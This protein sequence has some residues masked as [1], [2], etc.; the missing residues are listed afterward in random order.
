LAGKLFEKSV[1]KKNELSLKPTDRLRL[2]EELKP[3]E[4]YFFLLE[5]LWR[6]VDWEKLQPGLAFALGVTSFDLR[7][8]GI[9]TPRK[10]VNLNEDETGE[11]SIFFKMLS[12]LLL[13]LS[14]FGFLDATQNEEETK[15][16]GSKADF[17]AKSI[18]PSFFGVTL[19]RVL[20]ETREPARWNLPSRRASGE[21]NPQPAIPIP[22]NNPY[23]SFKRELNSLSNQPVASANLKNRK[24][25]EL[26]FL[27]F[28]PLFAEGEL[29]RTLP[30]VQSGFRMERTSSKSR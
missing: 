23:R 8:L 30:R 13:Y 27:P 24:A 9:M 29:Q 18:T 12:N 21:L 2:Y 1:G 10:E 25:D 11:L 26:F 7:L 14:L 28:V 22:S 3:A 5:T 4:K 17:F 15:R 6:D 20:S 16:C 19:A